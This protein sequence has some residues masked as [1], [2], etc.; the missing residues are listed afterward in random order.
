[1]AEAFLLIFALHQKTPTLS[2]CSTVAEN[3]V[4]NE[5]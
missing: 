4:F 2:M 3:Q 1:V 5:C